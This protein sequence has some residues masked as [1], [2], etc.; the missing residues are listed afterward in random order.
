MRKAEINK[1]E[2][3]AIN[4]VLA[5]LKGWLNTEESALKTNFGGSHTTDLPKGSAN[6]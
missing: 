3:E 4:K 6:V 2:R 1:K 5:S